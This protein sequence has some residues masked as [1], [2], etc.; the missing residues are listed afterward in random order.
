MDVKAKIGL[1]KA[2]AIVLVFCMVAG[3]LQ[4]VPHISEAATGTVDEQLQAAGYT[5]VTP[6]D[7]GLD[8]TYTELTRATEHPNSLHMTYLDMDVS[9][10][11]VT[12][13]NTHIRYAMDGKDRG[14]FICG[15]PSGNLMIRHT[16]DAT[17]YKS[18][19]GALQNVFSASETN[20]DVKETFNLKLAVKFASATATSGTV[21]YSIWVNEVLVAEDHTFTADGLGQNMGMM[22]MNSGDSISVSVPFSGQ[23]VNEQL[24]A[25]GYTRVTPEDFGLEGTY[26]GLNRTTE[27][28]NSLHMTYLDMDVSFDQVTNGNTHIRYAMDSKDRG[29]FICGYASGNLMIRHTSDATEHY[30]GKT[31]N[32]FSPSETNVNVKKTFNLKL[33]VKYASATAT[34]GTVTYSI[35]V[36]DVLV[37]K[38]HTFTAD[39]LGKKMG[40][41]VGTAGDSVTIG[42][43][44]VVETNLEQQLQEAGYTRVTP[45]LFGLN[46]TH[47]D[48]IRGILGDK[49][50]HKTYLDMDVTYHQVTDSDTCIRFAADKDDKGIIIGGFTKSGDLMVRH[51]NEAESSSNVHGQNITRVDLKNAETFNLKL[52][53][54]FENETATSGTIT[55][56]LWVNNYL[57]VA[58]GTFTADSFGNYMAVLIKPNSGDSIT[59]GTPSLTPEQY[60]YTKITLADF[61]LKNRSYYPNIV[62]SDH[63]VGTY[64]GSLHNKYLDVDLAFSENSSNACVRYASADGWTGISIYAVSEGLHLQS[65]SGGG[66]RT[67]TYAEMG[68]DATKG[69]KETF[70]LKLATKI[71]GTDLT[72]VVWVNDKELESLT[73]MGVEG[74]GTMAAVYAKM[75]V[76]SVGATTEKTLTPVAYDIDVD[77]TAQ[78]LEGYLVTGTEVQVWKNGELM[79]DIGSGDVLGD[80]LTEIGTYTIKRFDN[81]VKTT[82]TVCIYRLGDV[83]CN[84]TVELRDNGG[85]DLQLLQTML[86]TNEYKATTAAEFAADLDNDGNVG[87]KDLELMKK[88]QKGEAEFIDVKAKYHVPAISYDYLGGDEVMP[89]VGFY[90]PNSEA[91]ITDDMFQL[92]KDSGVNLITNTLRTIDPAYAGRTQVLDAME[93]AQKYG[94]GY[95]ADDTRL[96]TEMQHE[97]I[98]S[99][100]TAMDNTTLAGYLTAYSHYEN[101]LGTLIVDE[102]VP[103]NT[104]STSTWKKLQYYDNISKQLNSFS[105][106]HGYMNALPNYAS[107]FYNSSKDVFDDAA[108]IKYLQDMVDDADI[109]MLSFDNYPFEVQ[110]R[111]SYFETLAAVCKVAK[112]KNIPFWGYVQAGGNFNTTSKTVTERTPSET[113]TYWNVNT[114]LAF[115]AKGIAWFP[116]LQP[117]GFSGPDNDYGRNGLIDENYEKTSFYGYAQKMNKHIAAVDEVLMKASHK[118]VAVTRGKAKTEV[119]SSASARNTILSNVATGTAMLQSVSSN[120]STYGALVGCF[121][122]RDTEAFYVMN[123]DENG[124]RASQNVTL[125]FKAT[126]DYRIIKNAKTSFGTGNSVTIE[127]PAGEGVLI[128]LEDRMVEVS[129]ISEYRNATASLN[130]VPDAEPGYE[131]AGWYDES[132]NPI[133]ASTTS[134]TAYAK[135]VDADVM[136]VRAQIKANTTKDSET[137]DI[138]F[139]TTVDSVKYDEVGFVI[140]PEGGTESQKPVT[141][142]Y[143]RLYKATQGSVEEDTTISPTDVSPQSKY[144]TVYSY[145]GIA[146]KNFDKTFTV[147]PY[148][149]TIDGTTVYGDTV[150]KSISM[151]IRK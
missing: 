54:A 93:L 7:F 45:G 35:W 65:S 60:G 51:T 108:Y 9:F 107:D 13:G 151:G 142:V 30:S 102:P 140:T 134:G 44:A 40:I 55:Y 85:A 25:A 146:N 114:M 56:S 64:N 109:K 43:Q 84:G 137:T 138:R 111:K 8:G 53:V 29:I 92:I 76:V 16:S 27:Y 20:V 70:N 14:I 68:I 50:L 125:K 21:T 74:L 86:K 88:I 119:E 81:T 147:T 91:S 63:Y 5:R 69:L 115:G 4:Y 17:E 89:I 120:D 113:Q 15:Y 34:S 127:I 129:D 116:L 96:N 23:D 11:K 104:K 26:T 48:D 18:G 3:V 72:C 90:G 110:I 46:G 94:I 150:V 87:T 6:G 39:G 67:F 1:K 59:V 149:T 79:S 61:G 139:F 49:S 135:Y 58:D 112:E 28:P 100:P 143:E 19:T 33:A 12:N 42:P 132:G 36:N 77:G 148:W 47:K 24:Q 66:Y 136:T 145:W 83:N 62:P 123:Y 82:Q 80:S 31:Q 121:D 57:I 105:N 118:G 71:S 37:A 106:H 95:Y 38:N 128:V 133:A 103:N 2:K 52:A 141:T 126:Y 78:R 41:F 144:F 98:I 97:T 22:V 101:Y 122:Y 131:F 99:N 124:N 10:D 130:I 73:F 75:G 117:D 32:V